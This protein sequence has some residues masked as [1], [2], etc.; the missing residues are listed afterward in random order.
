MATHLASKTGRV[1]YNTPPGVI[2]RARRVLGEIDLDPASN[3]EAQSY[4]RARS[5]YTIHDDGLAH[6]WAGNVWL[7]PPYA[8]GLVEAFIG[9]V[10]DEPLVDQALVLVNNATDTRWARRLCPRATAICFT[11]RLSFT[12]AGEARPMSGNPRGQMVVALGD[13]DV[14]AFVR[15]FDDLGWTVIPY[16]KEVTS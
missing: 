2:E 11:K 3:E 13:I 9:K 10:L 16:R 8:S 7:N 5:Y 4:I 6:T 1:E 15:E 14:D 12:I